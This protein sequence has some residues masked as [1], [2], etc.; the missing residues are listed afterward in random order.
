MDEPNTIMVQDL[1]FDT[2]FESQSQGSKAAAEVRKR[3]SMHK[4][5]VPTRQKSKQELGGELVDVFK[6][7]LV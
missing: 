5:T 2:E 1:H 7:S 6:K 3:K 4:G